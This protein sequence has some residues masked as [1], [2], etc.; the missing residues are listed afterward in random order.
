V[1]FGAFRFVVRKNQIYHFSIDI[2]HDIRRHVHLLSEWVL[3]S[4]AFRII[5][6][7]YYSLDA[8]ERE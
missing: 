6:V 7:Q 5:P 1:L 8:I 4:F 3:A 2:W